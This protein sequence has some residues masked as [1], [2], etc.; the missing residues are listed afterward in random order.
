MFDSELHIFKNGEE[1]SLKITE[2]QERAV[3]AILGLKVS[4]V[5]DDT[6]VTFYSDK[7]LR[8]LRML[9]EQCY[10]KPAILVKE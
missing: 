1:L 8:P 3:F 9:V 5:P 4:R 7:T 10:Q 2:E 6:E